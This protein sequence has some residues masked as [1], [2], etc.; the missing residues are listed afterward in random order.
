MV[1]DIDPQTRRLAASVDDGRSVA[2]FDCIADACRNPACRCLAVTVTLRLRAPAPAAR[3][4]MPRERVVGVDLGT[5]AIDAKFRARASRSD[6]AFAATLLAAMEPADFDLLGRLH[7]AIKSRETERARPADIKA[8]FDFDEIE[9]SSILQ[10]Y[11]DI[12]PFAETIQL[13]VDG[14]EYVAL[15]QYCVRPGCDCT[16]AHVDFV[17]LA[18]GSEALQ[19]A[20]A[21][22]IDYQAGT[23]DLVENEPPPRDMAAFKCWLES[24]TPGLYGK[25]RARHKKLRAIYSHCR[26]RARAA[27]PQE[28]AGRNDPCP[29]GSGRKFKKCCMGESDRDPQAT[30]RNLHRRPPIAGFRPCRRG[31]DSARGLPI[32]RIVIDECLA[33]DD[34]LL[35]HWAARLGDRLVELVPLASRH[36]GIPDIEILDKLLDAHTALVTR[37]RVLHNRAIARGLRSFA[38]TEDGGLTHRKLPGVADTDTRP[39]VAGSLRDSYLPA[40]DSRAQAIAG[41]LAAFL[42]EHQLKRFRT[43]RRRIRAHFGSLDNIAATALTVGQIRTPEGIVG[44]YQLKVDA[45]HGIRSLVP[46]SE[47]YFLDRSADGGPLQS[48]VWSLALL[49]LLQLQGRPLTLFLCDAAALGYCTELAAGR[50]IGDSPVPYAVGTLLRTIGGV[51][52]QAC[53]KGRFFD[54]MQARL[55]QLAHGRGNE[56]VRIDVQAVAEALV[57]QAQ[58]ATEPMP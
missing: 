11:N 36:P 37:D 51:R 56:L 29:C 33:L 43:R 13:A 49:F 57:E 35:A 42:S 45:R 58:V 7:H 6:L 14:I 8:H 1:F 15:D 40:P 3:Q 31:T 16:A 26:K 5:K 20:A 22:G 47:S 55:R 10:A 27:V 17:A 54:R 12:L 4:G 53:A 32:E 18:E 34:A 28:P 19:S 23:W 44:G 48:V 39:P 21:V 38:Q 41:C 2:E 50:A 24:A 46:A 25:L 9:R 52:V 30:R